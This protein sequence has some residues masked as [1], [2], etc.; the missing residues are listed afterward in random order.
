VGF[1]E[2]FT[3]KALIAPLVAWTIAQLIKV[4]IEVVTNHRLDLGRLVSSGG[5]PS[6]HSA[7][8]S[9][10]ATMVGLIDGVGS[11]TF[12]ISVIFTSVVLYDAAGVR[13]SVGKQA[14]VLNRII[15]EFRERRSIA[16]LEA[17]LKELIGHTAFEVAAG[18]LLGVG[19]AF[20][21]FVFI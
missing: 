16:E 18:V 10:L 19:V 7:F 20:L 14:V 5:M 12:A 17:D 15:R 9:A 2:L 1:Y 6:S 3:N 4:V 21:W 13:H 11:I 8:V